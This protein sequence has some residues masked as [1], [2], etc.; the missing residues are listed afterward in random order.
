MI[1]IERKYED[2]KSGSYI[3]KKDY[4]NYNFK[5]Y[6]DEFLHSKSYTIETT[7]LKTS[8]LC[9]GTSPFD[10]RDHFQ[11]QEMS[12]KDIIYEQKGFIYISQNSCVNHAYGKNT[13]AHELGHALSTAFLKGSLSKS[14]YEKFMELRKC[15]SSLSKKHKNPIHSNNLHKGDHNT[16]EED[17]ADLISYLVIPDKSELSKCSS[18]VPKENGKSYFN[19]TLDSSDS[20]IHSATLLRILREAIHKRMNIPAS[21]QELMEQNKDKFRFE[22]CF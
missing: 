12:R 14:S 4:S 5:N 16:T 19:V 13:L 22:P 10:V 1:H 21:C 2:F 9:R 11:Y 15:A 3:Q 18:L 20:S 6:I 8:G 17:T 7:P